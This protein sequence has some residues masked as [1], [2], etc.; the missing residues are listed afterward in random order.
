VMAQRLIRTLCEACATPADTPTS[1]RTN[2][3]ELMDKG[4]AKAHSYRLAVGCAA[5]QGSGF[6]GRQGVFELVTLDRDL[7]RLIVGRSSLA[8]LRVSAV[9]AGH[10]TLLQDGMLKVERGLTTPEELLR[11]CGG[12]IED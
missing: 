5:C 11:A 12:T 9:K 3:L 1:S 10:R 2:S 4:S 6:R 8:E 7:H